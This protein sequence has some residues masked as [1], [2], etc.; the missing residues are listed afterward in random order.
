MLTLTPK[1]L[2]VALVLPWVSLPFPWKTVHACS[3]SFLSR[4]LPAEFWG[5]KGLFSCTSSVP[6]SVFAKRIFLK[7]YWV[8]YVLGFTS[9]GKSHIHKSLWNKLFSTLG[10]CRDCRG[11]PLNF[12]DALFFDWMILWDIFLDIF[13]ILKD[14]TIA[15]TASSLDKFY[16]KYPVFGLGLQAIFK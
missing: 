6:F 10:L 11:A 16:W 14:F 2:S 4:F 3:S 8:S 12:L 9:L 13:E 1:W 5:S 15:S 7:I